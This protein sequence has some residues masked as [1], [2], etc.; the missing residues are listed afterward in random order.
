MRAVL[1][2]EAADDTPADPPSRRCLAYVFVK[3]RNETVAGL[4]H[5]EEPARIT[6]HRLEPSRY[7]A[8]VATCW[9]APHSRDDLFSCGTMAAMPSWRDYQERA[10]AFFRTLGLEATTDE[11]INGARATHALDVAVRSRPRAGITQLWIVECKLWQRRVGKAHVATLGS[12]VQDV[13]AD[14]GIMLSESGFQAGAI[15]L[16]AHSNI[17]LTSLAD[18]HENAE[19]EKM[20]ADLTYFQSQIAGLSRLCDSEN[21]NDA[22]YLKL[23][24][25]S[26]RQRFFTRGEAIRLALDGFVQAQRDLWPVACPIID[27]YDIQGEIYEAPNLREFHSLMGRFAS[28]LDREYQHYLQRRFGQ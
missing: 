4:A 12:I 25:E 1:P 26:K 3:A 27:I 8:P 6:A 18:L 19:H 20:M 23:F 5:S 9:Q 7:R 21:Y 17:T 15:R 16:A 2:D 11:S 24:P 14:R 10:A 28:R 22:L 13:G